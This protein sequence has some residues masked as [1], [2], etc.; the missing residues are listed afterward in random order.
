VCKGIRDCRTRRARYALPCG[1]AANSAVI[2]TCQMLQLGRGAGAI[3]VPDAP[4]FNGSGC[5][6]WDKDATELDV[7]ILN[8]ARA[9]SMMA[10]LCCIL[11]HFGFCTFAN[12]C[13]CPMPCTQKVLDISVA[14]VQLSLALTWPMVQTAACNEFGGC[15]WAD[16]ST[17]LLLAQLFYFFASIFSRCMREPRY[18][19]KQ[20]EDAAAPK[21][22]AA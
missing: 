12:Q 10:P 11:A 19:R 2:G 15:T 5:T 18:K 6:C 20:N 7:W 9:C 4:I 14:G 3:S 13:L 1:I 16:G 22:D 8:M 17:A 21:Q